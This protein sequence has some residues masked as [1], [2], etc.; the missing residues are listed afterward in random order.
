MLIQNGFGALLTNVD[1]ITQNFDS[2]WR[3]LDSDDYYDWFGGMKNAADIFKTNGDTV[4]FSSSKEEI[5]SLK[6]RGY[7]LKP[8]NMEML[9]A[10]IANLA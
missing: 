2:T 1:L 10:T 5:M 8:I 3:F 7:L 9:L 6:P 4:T